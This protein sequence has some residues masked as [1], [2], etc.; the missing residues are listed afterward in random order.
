MIYY[1]M[2]QGRKSDDGDLKSGELVS[3]Y[4]LSKK[5][6]CHFNF[7]QLLR[8]GACDIIKISHTAV[9]KLG[10]KKFISSSAPSP[11]KIRHEDCFNHCKGTRFQQM[12]E[13]TFHTRSAYVD[14][15]STAAE[16]FKSEGYCREQVY[17]CLSSIN[18]PLNEKL[19][20][21][22]MYNEALSLVNNLNDVAYMVT[23]NVFGSRS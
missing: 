3:F 11:Q 9:Y 4:Q 1:R 5:P 16:N 13:Y 18:V 7:N 14:L 20:T 8:L 2:N 12:L 19:M 6:Y 23:L 15:M 21:N 10:L 17:F 22:K